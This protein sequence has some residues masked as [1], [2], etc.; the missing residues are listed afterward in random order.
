MITVILYKPEHPG[1]V[2]AVARVMANFNICR[3]VIISPRDPITRKAYDRASHAKNILQR[4]KMADDTVL[5]KFDLLV[6]TTAKLGSDY[7]LPRSVIS[8]ED[9]GKKLARSRGN[10]AIIFGPEA[11]GLPNTVIRQADIVV[12]VPTQRSY[13][14][15]NLSHATAILLYEIFKHRSTTSASSLA[16][17]KDRQIIHALINENLISMPFTTSSKRDAQR[18]LWHR[19]LGKAALTRR[20]AAG[21]MGFFRKA[22]K[23]LR[24]KAFII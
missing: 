11:H 20:E 9:L 3:L 17:A 18:V 6:A 22:R 8:P 12:T 10:V 23:N 1:N 5:K 2:G 24:S 4:A 16:T 19:V 13:P 7:N 15:L 14:V 21:L